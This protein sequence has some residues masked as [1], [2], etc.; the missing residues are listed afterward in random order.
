M[1]KSY[2]FLTATRISDVQCNLHYQHNLL[3]PF[4]AYLMAK[5]V[6]YFFQDF[7]DWF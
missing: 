5:L 7:K 1:A 4:N 3:L 2:E 6:V